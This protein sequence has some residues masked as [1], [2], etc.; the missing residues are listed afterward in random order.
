MEGYTNQN[1]IPYLYKVSVSLA[2]SGTAQ[3]TLIMQADSYFELR[4]ILGTAYVG[5]VGTTAA[6]KYEDALVNPNSFEVSIR[7][8]TTSFDIT[9]GRIPQRLLCGNAYNQILMQRPIAF[10]PQSNLFFDFLNLDTA[11]P[12]VVTLVLHGFKVR[13]S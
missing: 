5:A 11:N 7:D 4:A 9:N 8:Q 3:T 12:N 1:A 2:A 13:V 6:A 10:T